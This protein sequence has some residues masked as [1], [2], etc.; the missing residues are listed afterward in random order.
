[1]DFIHLQDAFEHRKRIFL[2]H[3]EKAVVR[4]RSGVLRD[5]HGT[6]VART[7]DRLDKL[8]ATQKDKGLNLLN[9]GFQHYAHPSAQHRNASRLIDRIYGV[10]Q[11][12][13]I[14]CEPDPVGKSELEGFYELELED[15][16]GIKLVAK[17][18]LLPQLFVHD[19]QEAPRKSWLITRKCKVDRY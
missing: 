19:T 10:L 7:Y 2:D 14:S 5:Q 16:F 4:E 13:G 18:G 11:T 12:C 1:M 8:I 3:I 9:V 15:E 6:Y 17:S